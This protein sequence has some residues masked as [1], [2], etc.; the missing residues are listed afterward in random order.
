MDSETHSMISRDCVNGTWFPDNFNGGKTNYS[1]LTLQYAARR[2]IEKYRAYEI[3]Y[4]Q[5]ITIYNRTK[6]AHTLNKLF[7]GRWR[8]GLIAFSYFFNCKHNDN[9]N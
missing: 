8:G 3:S 5:D 7:R 9:P 6:Y 1:H 4:E 2:E